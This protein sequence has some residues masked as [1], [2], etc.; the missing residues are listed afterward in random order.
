MFDWAQLT[1]FLFAS[2]RV[3]GFILFNPIL[4][5]SNIPAAFRTGMV[6]VLSI[7]VTSITEQQPPAPSGAVEL[8]AWHGGEY[9]LLCPPVGRI[10][11]RYPDGHDHEPD[12]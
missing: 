7:F 1:L 8:S 3:A 11:D 9:L 2:A 10:H 6:L 12:V 4:G 5:R